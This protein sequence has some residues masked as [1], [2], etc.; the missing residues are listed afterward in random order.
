MTMTAKAM[1]IWWRDFKE[2]TAYGYCS[3]CNQSVAGYSAI[4]VAGEDG[5]PTTVTLNRGMVR[6]QDGI[7]RRSA[8]YR[9]HAPTR[10]RTVRKAALA[11][12]QAGGALARYG[13]MLYNGRTPMEQPTRGESVA[14]G[15]LLRCPRRKCGT[16]LAVSLPDREWLS[17]H[18]QTG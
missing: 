7:F 12:E 9:D 15:T 3:F 17:R 2:T 18:P 1:P 8:K 13:A 11:M 10:G 14:S 6:G 16:L 5:P 4:R